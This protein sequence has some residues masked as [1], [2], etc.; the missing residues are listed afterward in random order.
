MDH[1]SFSIQ[2]TFKLRY[3]LNN[4]WQKGDD[5]PI[6]FYT[7]N[8]GSIETFAENTVRMKLD[9][10]IKLLNIFYKHILF[11]CRVCFIYSTHLIN[12]APFNCNYY[13]SFFLILY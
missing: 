5:A 7:G 1:F 8:E 6:L 13:V 2:D 9:N 3:L 4:T 12:L 11:Y 10:T